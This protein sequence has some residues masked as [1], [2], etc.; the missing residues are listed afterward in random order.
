MAESFGDFGEVHTLR[1]SDIGK[2]AAA[3]VGFAGEF[4]TEN[5]SGGLID[6]VAD[7]GLG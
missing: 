7:A 5:V 3:V 4:V 2:G 6:N 1:E